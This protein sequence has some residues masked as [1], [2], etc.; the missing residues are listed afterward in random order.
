MEAVTLLKPKNIIN[1]SKNVSNLEYI[2]SNS[3]FNNRILPDKYC[4]IKGKGYIVLDFGKEYFGGIRI[5]FGNNSYKKNEPFLR[6]R[7]GES[8]MEANSELGQKGSSNDHS[9]RDMTVY[10]S[11]HSDMVWGSTGFRFVRLDFIEEADYQI[12]NIFLAFRHEEEPKLKFK[13][14]NE[15][16]DSI[17]NAA[18]H[19]LF[20]NKQHGVFF[21]GAKRDQHIWAGDL[22]PELTAAI[23]SFDSLENVKNSLDFIIDNYPTP[24]WYNG[25]PSYNA[26]FVLTLLKYFDLTGD[27]KD[28]YLSCISSNLLMFKDLISKN[29]FL[30]SENLWGLT[31]FDWS[32]WNQNI[33]LIGIK[34][35]F[36][37]VLNQITLSTHISSNDK[38]IASELLNSGL[39]NDV[40]EVTNSKVVNSLCLL[41]GKNNK[42]KLISQIKQNGCE[43]FSAFLSCFILE[44]L[45]QN[46]ELEFAFTAMLDYFG[47][48][49]DIGGTTL[50]EEFDLA[51][52]KNSCKLD[53]V[54]KEGQNDFHG[55]FGSDC[56]IGYRKSLCHGWSCGIIPF[57]LEHVVGIQIKDG[58]KVYL[59]P[60]LLSLDF[61]ECEIP[62]EK[63][64]IKIKL[65]QK[66]N[67]INK[68]I[69]VPDTFEYIGDTYEN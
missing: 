54:P 19:T 44:S 13:S 26:W 32:T 52:T 63:G 58:N 15:R 69:V 48:M 20:L 66:N 49:L 68:T 24:I 22:Y 33:S 57:V 43:G 27:V 29:F 28:K 46:N 67:H 9:T 42:D 51:W 59:N 35:L 7:F 60:N 3:F 47:G 8:L 14:S 11:S 30:T 31:F 64:F 61:V 1:H 45:S 53:E 4:E 50:F 37:Y 10:M 17:I 65:E 12:E 6:I 2:F 18:L 55:D 41:T 25:I 56:F 34:C 40:E 36:K 21:E 5:S 16:L 39:L 38:E 62:T 23:Y